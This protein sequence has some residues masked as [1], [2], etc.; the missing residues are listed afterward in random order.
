MLQMCIACITIGEIE[1]PDL[2]NK[3][4]RRPKLKGKIGD[5]QVEFLVDSGASVSVCSDIMLKSCWNHWNIRRLPLPQSLRL[6]GVTGHDINIVDYVEIEVEVENRKIYRP[7]LI[8]SGLHITHCILG[9]DFIK[10]EGL[11]ID[12]ARDKIYFADNPKRK[13]NKAAIQAIHKTSIPPRTIEH[14]EVVARTG[15]RCIEEG[16]TAFCTLAQHSPFKFY[17]SLTKIRKGGQMTLAIINSTDSKLTLQPDDTLGFAYRADSYFDSVEPLTEATVDS[18]F[19]EIGE[20]PREPRRGKIGESTE[21]E[22]K[23]LSRQ[24][25]ILT[26]DEI[27]REKYEGLMLTYHDVCSKDKFD[28]G[29]AKVIK[30][31]IQMKDQ[32]P[33]HARQFRIPFAHEEVI[34][35]YVEELLKKGAIEYSRSPYNSPIFCV[36]KKAPPNADPNSPPPLRVVLDYRQVNANSLPDRYSMKEV[37]ECIDEIGKEKAKIF[38]TVDLTAGFWQQELEENSRQYTA[39]SVP[40]KSAR[41]Q[42]CVTPM[43]L[44]GSPASFA[45]LM[46][47]V[48]RQ[49][50]GVLTYIDDVLV[51]ADSHEKHY[52]RLEEVLL[53]L[54]KYGLKLNVAKTLIGGDTVQYLGYTI[55]QTGVT[56]STSK[57]E[58][59]EKFEPPKDLRQIREFVGLCNYFRFLIP[60][61]SRL[62]APL[63][64]LT[65]KD[66]TWKGGQLPPTASS[67]FME[68][69]E[70][71]CSKPV[72][73]Y[74]SRE[75]KFI[76]Y[77]DA[78]LGEPN[79]PGG[80]GAALLQQRPDGQI[81]V[82]AYASRSLRDHEKNY[83]AYLLE[84]TAACWAID[85]F[86]VYLTGKRFTLRTDHKPLETLTT[87]HTKTLNRLQ[88][89]MLQY[90]F[91]LEYT[92]G[93]ENPVADFLSRNA[94]EWG[95]IEYVAAINAQ[96]SQFRS[97][98]KADE[99]MWK[100]IRYLKMN[101]QQRSK[102]PQRIKALAENCFLSEN[103]FLQKKIQLSGRDRE[104]AWPPRK[105]RQPI[106]DAAHY[107]LEAGHGGRDRTINRVKLAYWWPGMT[108]DIDKTIKECATCQ[109]TK[110]KLPAPLPLQSMPIPR[111]PNNRV[112]ID[113]MGPLRTSENGNKYIM[114]MTDA[115]T[116]WVELAAIENKTAETIGKYF[117]ERWICRFSAPLCIITDQG[118]E[119]NNKIL[120]EICH[121]WKI[122]KKRTSP[123]HPQTNSSAESYNRSLL[124]YLRA[125]LLDSKHSTLDWEPLLASAQLA[126]NCH[127][128]KS[129][130]ESPFFL[131]YLHDPRLPFFD[132]N[133]PRRFTDDS[134]VHET[135]MIAQEAYLSANKNMQNA[136]EIQKKY[137][138]EGVKERKV[139]AGERVMIYF[140]NP[141][142]KVNPKLHTHWKLGT[143][144]QMI[145]N[146]NVLVALDDSKRASLV[147][148]NRVRAMRTKKAEQNSEQNSVAKGTSKEQEMEGLPHLDIDFDVDEAI[149][150]WFRE[151]DE[152]EAKQRQEVGEQIDLARQ[153]REI[154]E[155]ED[156]L[157]SELAGPEEGRTRRI[158]IQFNPNWILTDPIPEQPDSTTNDEPQPST[159]SGATGDQSPPQVLP[160]AP[161]PV[162]LPTNQQTEEG[163]TT[164]NTANTEKNQGEEWPT[165][166]E[167]TRGRTT[168][169][170]QFA[171]DKETDQ[172]KNK[173]KRREP[174]STSAPP[175]TEPSS[176]LG[177]WADLGRQVFPQAGRYQTRS[178]GRASSPP[179]LP[180]VPLEYKRRKQ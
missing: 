131:T 141:P 151:L 20:E 49:T 103:G 109:L 166:T 98:Q 95:K 40:G 73:G 31:K 121:L 37:R 2:D 160:P 22:R 150:D 63:I 46:D 99:E 58:A 41:Y 27:W 53:R 93:E 6:S 161:V 175:R 7:M 154:G 125:M 32:V 117:F 56:L 172:I 179:S 155:Q 105:L 33:I 128:H 62:T 75:G 67:S 12:G 23:E 48:M 101:T 17:D 176:P 112:H 100:V 163:N 148:L 80:L 135:F 34:Y 35:D 28:L 147:H 70:K 145:G 96:P 97:E 86:S 5:K 59:I 16:E 168:L 167:Q 18:I 36:A 38:T 45:R 3:G 26:K 92:A 52:K 50:E 118:K 11:I 19:G 130:Q 120:Q 42:F 30:H 60:H 136:A 157:D 139:H 55:S 115:F 180:E 104:V 144:I 165:T 76:L 14:I 173:R 89:L 84:M 124:K 47:H 51:H 142:P 126:Y 57:T 94:I 15:E 81:E 146:L 116:K 71:L 39:F 127:I 108:S 110:S 156:A 13:W 138:D 8:V 169:K 83:S 78:A 123:F 164:A 140:P 25:Q 137:Y 82:I 122:D 44:Q 10:E 106:I 133:K 91:D 66:S 77:S 129:T 87:V 69:K 85:H 74:P 24:L 4:R 88:Q 174:K 65:K 171:D 29:H 21:K 102:Q 177:P 79:R 1:T 107:T 111:G 159:S 134:F 54:R 72:V 158:R 132:L 43:G 9:Y 61:F 90:E 113:L 64:E 152:W 153:Q 143:V 119:F 114:V 178:S 170:V 68:L 149:N 162:A